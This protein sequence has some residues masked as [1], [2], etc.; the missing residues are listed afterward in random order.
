MKKLLSVL[1]ICGLMAASAVSCAGKGETSSATVETTAAATTAEAATETETEPATEPT[2]KVTVE[3]YDGLIC[4]DNMTDKEKEKSS[5]REFTLLDPDKAFTIGKC[6]LNSYY[7]YDSDKSK[8]KKTKDNF[9]EL[10]IYDEQLDQQFLVHVTLPPNYDKEKEYTVVFIT[11]SAYHLKK[12]PDLWKLIDDGEASPV[13]FVILGYDYDTREEEERFNKFILQDKEFLDFITDDLMKTISLNYKV[14][15]S[16][17]VFFGHSFGGAF[18]HYALCNSDN[19]EYQ[20]FANYIIGSPSFY[21]Y[22]YPDME[23]F[24]NSSIKDPY[25]FQREFDYFDRNE[26][27]DKNVLICAGGREN[28]YDFKAPDDLPTIPEE[29]KLL[30]ERLVS[31]GAN[32]ELKI[33]EDCYRNNY[34]AD[35]LK[36]YLKQNFPPEDKTQN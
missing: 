25:A 36:D 29:A 16:R 11:D 5:F 1:L 2:T 21:A 22:F 3:Y 34:L 20:P 24:D 19:Y 31:H 27:M 7:F 8:L 4:S 33:Y 28:Y 26:T 18:S 32:A 9:R 23:Y 35:M 14:D 30:H 13:I 10:T 15:A 17:S 12:V 6:G